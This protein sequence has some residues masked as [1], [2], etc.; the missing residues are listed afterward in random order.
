MSAHHTY[1]GDPTG[2]CRTCDLPASECAKAQARFSTEERIGRRDF[3][4]ECEDRP[5]V[6]VGEDLMDKLATWGAKC[7]RLETR[8]A[9][10]EETLDEHKAPKT[11]ERD[12]TLNANGRL[13]ELLFALPSQ[14]QKPQRQDSLLDQIDSVLQAARTMGCYDAEDWIRNAA[15]KP[16]DRATLEE[17]F[18]CATWYVRCLRDVVAQRPVRGLA[19]AE[20]GYEKSLAEVR[21]LLDRYPR[22]S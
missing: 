2:V 5:G 19:E 15:L 21:N 3:N 14:E 20:G 22:P 18:G 6:S 1:V 9:A 12:R 17:F 13:V 10:V 16:S 7:D 4:A 8:L 11:D